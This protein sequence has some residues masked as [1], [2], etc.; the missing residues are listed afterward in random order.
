MKTGALGA[1]AMLASSRLA[2][3]FARTPEQ[4]VFRPYPPEG[5]PPL[6]WAY[7]SD[8]DVDP[9]KSAMTVGKEGII[10]PDSIGQ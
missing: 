9:F 7:A 8:V 5:M 4:L 2:P 3:L 10:A 1:G 6:T